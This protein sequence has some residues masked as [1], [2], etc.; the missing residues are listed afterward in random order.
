MD[1]ISNYG[2]RK[3]RYWPKRKGLAASTFDGAKW[4]NSGRQRESAL[5]LLGLGLGSGVAAYL[6]GKQA[7]EAA[8]HA[9]IPETLVETHETLALIT[10]I[11]LGI[12]FQI[13]TP[14][15]YLTIRTEQLAWWTTPWDT[16]PNKNRLISDRA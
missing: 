4:E 7:E 11:I 13:S 16:L 3:E 9:G 1:L 6:S 2:I 5:W 14:L 15:I 12:L 10:L 8:E